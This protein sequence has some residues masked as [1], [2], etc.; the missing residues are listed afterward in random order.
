MSYISDLRTWYIVLVVP[1]CTKVEAAHALEGVPNVL[2]LRMKNSL[3]T[4][5][6]S[7][8]CFYHQAAGLLRLS[9]GLENTTWCPDGRETLALALGF[10][11]MC[12]T[13]LD[14]DLA[15]DELAGLKGSKWRGLHGSRK[16]LSK[17]TVGYRSLTSTI[18]AHEY[19]PT[20]LLLQWRNVIS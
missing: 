5:Y 14:W 6:F 3:V 2:L 11:G 7:Q 18:E 13:A 8:M 20:Y 19:R 1:S 9:C 10:S 12:M 15:V 17:T 4:H 16:D